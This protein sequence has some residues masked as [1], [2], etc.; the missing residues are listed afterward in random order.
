MLSEYIHNFA[1]WSAARAVQ[2]PHN[3]GTKTILIK[4][5]IEKVN[6]SNYVSNPELLPTINWFII[7]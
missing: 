4:A 2:N 5:A 3:W 7:N 1:C 6:L